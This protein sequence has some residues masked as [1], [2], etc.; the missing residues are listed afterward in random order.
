[1]FTIQEMAALALS[2][3]GTGCAEVVPALA[4]ALEA[5]APEETRVAVARALGELGAEAR[6]AAPQ[7]RALLKDNSSRVRQ[8]AGDA[9]GMIEGE[10]VPDPKHAGAGAEA[11]D[12]ELAEAERSYLWE[13][14]HHGNLLV[15]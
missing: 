5:A 2:R 1:G 15:K 8:A 13:I 9:L 11:G 7:L 6:P 10:L 12:L 4:A 3:A 14:E